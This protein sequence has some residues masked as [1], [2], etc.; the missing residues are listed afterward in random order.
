MSAEARALIRNMTY[1]AGERRGFSVAQEPTVVMRW[2]KKEEE[3]EEEE[4]DE[5]GGGRR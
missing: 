4:E 1:A 5:E 3:E 2:K